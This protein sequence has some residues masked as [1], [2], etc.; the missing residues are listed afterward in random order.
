[1]I[2]N[3]CT[4]QLGDS[5]V[6]PD[7]KMA[8][9]YSAGGQVDQKGFSHLPDALVRM[10][11]R[12]KWDSWLDLLHVTAPGWTQSSQTYYLVAQNFQRECSESPGQK[13]LLESFFWPSLKSLRKSFLPYSVGEVTKANSDSKRMELDSTPPISQW[14]NSSKSVAIV[15]L[16]HRLH[17]NTNDNVTALA[18]QVFGVYKQGF[19]FVMSHVM[20]E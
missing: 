8:Q 19:C 12:F 5:S 20:C 14:R 4:V 15:G 9:W 18:S 10:A 2:R 3:L 11:R 16:P 6:L 13:L 17:V 1:M 7:A